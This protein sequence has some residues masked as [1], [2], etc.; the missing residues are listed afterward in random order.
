[1]EFCLDSNEASTLDAFVAD[2]RSATFCVKTTTYDGEQER[3]AVRCG[4]VDF[5]SGE[6]A[7]VQPPVP[8]AMPLAAVA[9]K[10]TTGGVELCRG[11]SCARLDLP[12]PKQSDSGD[13]EPYD[14]VVSDD[15]RRAVATGGSLAGMALFDAATGKR[16]K[17]LQIG[18][19]NDLICIEPARFVGDSIYVSANLCAKPGSRGYLFSKAGRQLGVVDKVNVFG[20]VPIHVSGNLYAFADYNGT[21]IAIVNVRTGRQ[22]R[23]LDLPRPRDC[24][25]CIA[26]GDPDAASASPLTRTPSGKLVAIAGHGITWIDPST[27]KVEKVARL[28]VC[29]VR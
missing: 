11:E 29:P 28:P 12:G 19:D 16:Q 13:L 18:S 15:G 9:V 5:A 23:V 7:E 4:V 25:D 17:T 8:A 27:G 2:E 21:G 20:A 6:F 24:D 26:L 14:I 22:V 1:M 3:S 10:Q